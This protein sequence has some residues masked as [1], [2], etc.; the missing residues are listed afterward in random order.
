M[1]HVTQL[2]QTKQSPMTEQTIHTWKIW[3]FTFLRGMVTLAWSSTPSEVFLL[4]NSKGSTLKS[5]GQQ[6]LSFQGRPFSEKAWC[7]QKHTGTCRSSPF[8]KMLKKIYQVYTN[9]LII[10]RLT[11]VPLGLI[12]R[13][14]LYFFTASESSPRGAILKIWSYKGQEL[15]DR[16]KFKIQDITVYSNSPLKRHLTWSE[17]CRTHNLVHLTLTLF[18]LNFKKGREK[19]TKPPVFRF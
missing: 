7:T 14:N 10:F 11:S 17:S 15:H 8:D 16:K 6:I 5:L 12:I 13:L 9:A 4:P 3:F 2:L 19:R 18:A 1:K